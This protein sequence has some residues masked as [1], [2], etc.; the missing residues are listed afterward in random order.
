M[1]VAPAV[2]LPLNGPGGVSFARE[3]KSVEAPQ[4]GLKELDEAG[5]LPGAL[6]LLIELLRSYNNNG[7]AALFG[8]ALRSFRADTAKQLAEAGLGVV[9]L[10]YRLLWIAHK[11]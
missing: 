8:H 9:Q 5:R 11:P 3:I 1:A 10:P 7:L 4:R 6:S 2:Q